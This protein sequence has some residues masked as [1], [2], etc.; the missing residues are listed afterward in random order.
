LGTLGIIRARKRH[1]RGAALG[2]C[3]VV[4]GCVVFFFARYQAHTASM[5]RELYGKC[6]EIRSKYE[7]DVE[8]EGV[9]VLVIRGHYT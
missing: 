8:A 9:E 6:W 4:L 7:P 1:T 2:W 3:A 5:M